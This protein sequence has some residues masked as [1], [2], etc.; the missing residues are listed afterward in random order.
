MML[1]PEGVEPQYY[2]YQENAGS[3]GRDDE[4]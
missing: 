3:Y 4:N 1:P 2:P